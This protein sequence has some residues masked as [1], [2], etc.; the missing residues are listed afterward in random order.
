ML[1]PL[2]AGV[3]PVT[4][5]TP[6]PRQVEGPMRPKSAATSKGNAPVFGRLLHLRLKI[7]K[8]GK[9]KPQHETAR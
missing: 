4:D 9:S 5:L 7:D 6:T 3:G 2:A 8:S 1:A